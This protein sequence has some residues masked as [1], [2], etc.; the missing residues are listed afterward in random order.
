MARDA[1][2]IRRIALEQ[3]TIQSHP[4]GRMPIRLPGL[5]PWPHTHLLTD[6]H[7]CHLSSGFMLLATTDSF[8]L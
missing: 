2:A 3:V 7:K 4:I 6:H 5:S 1:F 8:A